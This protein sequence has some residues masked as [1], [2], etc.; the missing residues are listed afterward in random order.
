ML[1]DNLAQWR[2]YGFGPAWE[3]VMTWLEE[4]ARLSDPVALTD[5]THKAGACDITVMSLTTRLWREARYE[6][7]RRLCDVHMAL[8]GREWFLTAPIAAMAPDGDFDVP[9]DIGFHRPLPAVRPDGGAMAEC[10]E[11]ARLTLTPGIFV[12]V[13]PWDA[14]MPALAVD[15][16]PAPLRKCIAKIPL[17]AL[18]LKEPIPIK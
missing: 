2:R 10:R 4:A 15:D 13:F 11:T 3:G 5:G 18:R 16:R 14:H 9:G 8:S 17:D 7:H 12:L 1:V 6:T